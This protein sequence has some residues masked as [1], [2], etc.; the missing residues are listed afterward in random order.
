M[1]LFSG[2]SYID[3]EE[4]MSRAPEIKFFERA[5][6]LVDNNMSSL[7]ENILTEV[8]RERK[9]R[10]FHWFGKSFNG[11]ARR[12]STSDSDFVNMY[13][14]FSF[15]SHGSLSVICGDSLMDENPFSEDAQLFDTEELFWAGANL[16]IATKCYTSTWNYIA[17]MLK[18][19]QVTLPTR[20]INYTLF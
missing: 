20:H 11:L 18:A 5:K 13:S 16:D 12:I 9:K 1:N 15:L 7:D 17:I 19:N 6:D 8:K 3:F 14:Y 2:D 10:C 4:F